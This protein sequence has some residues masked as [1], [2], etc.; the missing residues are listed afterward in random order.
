MELKV[1]LAKLPAVIRRDILLYPN[2]TED[3]TVSD[4]ILAYC[5]VHNIKVA[6]VIAIMEIL[7]PANQVKL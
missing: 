5:E 1:D 6:H 2:T 3:I 4:A 7:K